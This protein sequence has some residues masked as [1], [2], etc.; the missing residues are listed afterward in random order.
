MAGFEVIIEVL[1]KGF[2]KIGQMEEM[3]RLQ[4]EWIRMQ[5]KNEEQLGLP[6]PGMRLEI[7]TQL[8]LISALLE[9]KIELGFYS[10]H[11]KSAPLRR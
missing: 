1:A 8:K 4:S 9:K 6:L 10:R 7:E 11:R 2:G 5:L 3:I